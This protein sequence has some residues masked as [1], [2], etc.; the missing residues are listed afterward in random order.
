MAEAMNRRPWVCPWGICPHDDAQ[1]CRA[2]TGQD[3]CGG[4]FPG[5]SHEM[6]RAAV[7]R[8]YAPP[9]PAAPANA[10]PA[11][12]L[13]EERVREIV[14]EELA[15]NAGVSLIDGKTF[16]PADAAGKEWSHG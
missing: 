10:A 7:N 2:K 1:K 12:Q 3:G 16:P 9:A 15:R 5:M 11:P 6:A 4:R 13:T 8:R 14:R